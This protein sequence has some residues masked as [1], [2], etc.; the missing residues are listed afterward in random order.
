MRAMRVGLRV[1]HCTL[2]TRLKRA[3]NVRRALWCAGRCSSHTHGE[4]VLY[5]QMRACTLEARARERKETPAR[6]QETPAE[7][8][9]ACEGRAELA[10]LALVLFRFARVA[11]RSIS[12]G[13]C[14]DITRRTHVH[15]HSYTRIRTAVQIHGYGHGHAYTVGG[16][17]RTY[18]HKGS[19]RPRAQAAT[20]QER[21]ATTLLAQVHGVTYG[22]LGWDPRLL[23]MRRGSMELKPAEGAAAPRAR[24]MRALECP[25]CSTCV[26]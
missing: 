23:A 17:A 11:I 2:F 21:H 9:G 22:R 12:N 26:L 20:L 25:G 13:S 4:H 19:E 18:T 8:V 7:L 3:E 6:P 16:G 15:T 14:H 5:V 10:T 1:C 24:P